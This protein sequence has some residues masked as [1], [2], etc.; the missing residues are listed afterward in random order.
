MD[1]A[2]S[3]RYKLT[4]VT[5]ALAVSQFSP[6]LYVSIVGFCKSL[7]IIVIV[8]IIVLIFVIIVPI[9]FVNVLFTCSLDQ[10]S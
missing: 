2:K 5:I 8:I 6:I 1:L 4:A 9:I 3:A 10:S 7:L